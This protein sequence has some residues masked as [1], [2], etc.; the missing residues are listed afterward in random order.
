MDVK[1]T[2]SRLGPTFTDSSG[3]MQGFG[4][5]CPGYASETT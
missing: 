3:T 1:T 2:W 4:A 5:A